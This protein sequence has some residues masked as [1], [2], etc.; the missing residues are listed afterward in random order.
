MSRIGLAVAAVL[1]VLSALHVAW[2]L[3][4]GP[5]LDGVVPEVDGRPTFVPGP[6]ATL[7]VAACLAG[8]AGT[9][10]TRAGLW[11]ASPLPAPLASWGTWALAAIFLARAVGDF[12][13][14]G[15]TK[16][17]RGTTFARRDTWL[18][19]PL[20]AGLGLALLYLATR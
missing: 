14:I 7:V 5:A 18:Y 19:S 9:V 20:C 8:A 1:L 2:A 13:L 4:L 15:F 17:I 16:R 6:L 11:E 10:L 3:G 12:R